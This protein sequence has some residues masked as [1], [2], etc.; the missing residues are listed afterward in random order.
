MSLDARFLQ[1]AV[2]EVYGRAEASW[3]DLWMRSQWDTGCS[4]MLEELADLCRFVHAR[5]A[6]DALDDVAAVHALARIAELASD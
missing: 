2:D 1:S 6:Q 5:Y 3:V 4:P